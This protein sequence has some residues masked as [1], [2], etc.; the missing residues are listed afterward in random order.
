MTDQTGFF[1]N[2]PIYFLVGPNGQ[3]ALMGDQLVLWTDMDAANSFLEGSNAAGG[4]IVEVADP[5]KITKQFQHSRDVDGLKGAVIDPTHTDQPAVGA[6]L[7]E[8]IERFE[9]I[10]RNEKP[11]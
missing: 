5:E 10:Q 8:L 4:R 2:P 9:R 6:T 11:R 1:I 3:I 7:D